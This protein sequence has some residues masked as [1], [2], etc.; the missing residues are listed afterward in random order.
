MAGNCTPFERSSSRRPDSAHGESDRRK[1]ALP[2]L[3]HQHD[4]APLHKE[5][6]L[7]IKLLQEESC[8][9]LFHSYEN[10]L[11]QKA[12]LAA[13]ISLL[14][15]DAVP[16]RWF[17]VVSQPSHHVLKALSKFS[18]SFEYIPRWEIGLWFCT[19]P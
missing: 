1:S 15:V 6:Q 8:V 3:Q 11:Y 16:K 7:G 13:T 19:I 5:R 9:A 10:G 18:I 14:F 12:L 4:H 2:P 17:P